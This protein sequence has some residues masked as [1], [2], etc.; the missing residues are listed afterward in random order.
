MV[1][2][3]EG[4]GVDAALAMRLG[5]SSGS[6]AVSVKGPATASVEAAATIAAAPVESVAVIEGPAVGEIAVMVIECVMVVPVESPMAPAPSKAAE[7]A[8]SETDAEREIRAAIP[9]TGI[10]IPSW[11][12]DDG[13]AINGPGIVSGHV[14]YLGIS[15]LNNDRGALGGYSLLRGIFQIAGFFRFLAHHLH[16]IH[17]VLLLVVVSVAKG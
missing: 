11:P 3:A 12:G 5:V 13:A 10:R 16:G 2:A 14:D 17:D 8:D 6:L 1:V 4:A 7:E 9:D 15:G